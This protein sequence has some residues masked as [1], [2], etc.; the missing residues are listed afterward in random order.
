MKPFFIISLFLL[1]TCTVNAEKKISL[2]DIER[3]NLRNENRPAPP[4]TAVKS[5]TQY[6]FVPT[7]T[8]HDYAQ[9]GPKN[10]YVQPQYVPTQQYTEAQYVPTQQYYTTQYQPQTDQYQQYENVQ[11]VTDNSIAQKPQQ[12]VYLQQY[13]SPSSSVQH[14]VDTK[15]QLQYIMY[16]PSYVADQSQTYENVVYQPQQ[17]QQEEA[18]QY[19][20]PEYT[21]Q[22]QVEVAVQPKIQ[23]QGS[24][25]Q[26]V[27]PR[28]PKS[29]LD[30]Y[31][32]SILQIQYYKQQ[33]QGLTNSL[34]QQ[35]K[36]SQPVTG[37]TDY[38]KSYRAQNSYRQHRSRS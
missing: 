33:Q 24:N 26:Y 8:I 10:Q 1:G 2:E 25:T 15:G 23:Y 35:R 3:D 16:I 21:Q 37:K 29:L 13:P 32:P 14:I 28:E 20:V 27:Q 34:A 19:T 36:V 5:P 6:G 31:V 12:Y 17:T 9:K 18:V 4:S 11:Y 7:K 38:V 30:S 22:K